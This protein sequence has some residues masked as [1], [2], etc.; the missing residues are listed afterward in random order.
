MEV[1]NI[2]KVILSVIA[3][4]LGLAL[5]LSAIVP[6]S[7]HAKRTGDNAYGKGKE[8]APSIKILLK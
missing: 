2:K 8:I 1:V 7:E 5:I 4:A 6:V 3:L